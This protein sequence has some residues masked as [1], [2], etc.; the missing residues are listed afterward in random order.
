MNNSVGTVE[1]QL[2]AL[3]KI[4]TALLGSE[5]HSEQ[6]LLD[7]IGKYR[8]VAAP[9][10]TDDDCEAL[11]KLLSARLSIDLGVGD[12]LTSGDYQPWLEERKPSIDWDRWL[13]YKQF[14]LNLKWSP[15][16]VDKMDEITDK[17]LDL[18][19]DPTLADGWARRGLVLGDVQS[20]K[21]AS[22][23]ALFNKAADAGYRL[24]IVL[25]GHT[26]VLRQQTQSRIDEGFIGIDS[27]LN[28]TRPGTRVE[29]NNRFIGVGTF[30]RR[31]ASTIGMTTATRDFTKSSREATTITVTSDSTSPYIFVVKKNKQVLTALEEWL[32][33]QP[34]TAGR[35]DIPLLLLDDESDYA[36]VNT[37]EEDD[38]TAINDA[39][40][41]ILG[42]FSRS[43]YVAFT[44]TPFANIFIDHENDD[45]LFPKDFIYSL[46]SP[47][48]YVG[49]EKVFGTVDNLNTEAV[50]KL[51]DAD[52]FF[53][54]AHRASLVVE[55]L[56]ESL[57]VAIRSFFIANAIR[58]LR[59]QTN[60]HR[61]MLINVSRYKRVQRQVGALVEVEVSAIRN[62]VQLYAGL[63]A[64]GEL[65]S[66]LTNLE[67]C[68]EEI[69]PDT[70]LSWAEILK[71]LPSAVADIRV[72]VFNS[73]R[74]RQLD[75]LDLAWDRPRRLVAIGGDV[76]SRGLTLD[77]LTTSYFYRRT[78]ASDTMLQMARW[79]GYRD[80][81]EDICRIWIDSAVAA[82]Y[83]FVAESVEELRRD[84]RSML[85]QR[86]T[87]K[88]FGLAVRKHPG[89]LL[90][91]A[92][93]KM[94]A[95]ETKV[96]T[97]S[98]IG[99][100]IETT[101]L[102]PELQDISSNDEHMRSFIATINSMEGVERTRSRRKYHLWRGV[103][104]V[105][106]ADYL[107][108]FI[109]S[110]SDEL[111]AFGAISKF[112]RAAGTPHFQTWDV[113]LV[114]GS[115]PAEET[116]VAD[117]AFL[118][119]SR[120]LIRGQDGEIRLGGQSARLAGA[121]D[122]TNL[123]KAEI[124]AGAANEFKSSNRD[125]SVPESIYYPLLDR[126]ALL[127][128]ALRPS[129]KSD[130]ELTTRFDGNANYVVALK[131]AFPGDSSDCNSSAGDVQYVINSV[132]VQS[133]FAEYQDNQIDE[134]DA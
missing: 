99:R 31:S 116:L 86:L 6:D 63:H 47:D 50:R 22:Y 97:I 131:L 84:L 102:S 114:N 8:L 115:S 36:S 105:E 28:V 67:R 29:T 123:M 46:E 53:P 17:I 78:Q 130:K 33:N 32:N 119:P 56:P 95:A 1:Q 35:L 80:G 24:I 51:E 19:G 90:V 121:D 77:G 76:L 5:T 118:P 52:S 128:Y 94:K 42:Q 75:E 39:I 83:R 72:Q 44:A 2:D 23:V 26:E 30:N 112:V 74:D 13:A 108:T 55:A 124:V 91:T 20:G 98:L 58:D 107:S 25:A 120:Q 18:V 100:R 92:K 104:K 64:Q 110:Q 89:A 34:K 117:I 10:A 129:G 113:L 60:Q 12:V 109:T 48:N 57:H 87:P 65:S 14:L 106:V 69:Y 68:F 49:S 122:L 59:G 126:P 21:T 11:A 41:K 85:V 4:T 93:N 40:R 7:T 16:V 38:P 132:A 73:D 101:K 79:F 96:K 61:A 9:N 3:E 15:R 62:A 43:S 70:E 37:R 134:L 125:K 66:E 127:I 45:D 54:L 88:D 82:D 103:P 81:Y 111:F 133:W 27:S 71:A